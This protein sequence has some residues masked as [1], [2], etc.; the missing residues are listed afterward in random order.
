MEGMITGSINIDDAGTPGTVSKSDFLPEDR[1]SWAAVIIPSRVTKELNIALE[2]F[3]GGI[4][5]D[6]GV[7]EFH[8]ADIYG[9]R[10]QWKGIPVAKRIEIFELMAM[11]IERF[12]LPIIYQT[13]SK[14]FLNDHPE[15][16]Q[17]RSKRGAWWDLQNISHLSLLFLCFQISKYFQ[18][19]QTKFPSDFP[20]PFPT[21]VDE[22]IAKAGSI[23]E[24][25]NWGNAIQDQ[26]LSFVKSLE[27]PGI[28][29]ADFAA[30][31]ISRTQWL[32]AKQEPGKSLSEGDIK[33]MAMSG[34]LN[35][36]NLPLV[37]IDPKNHSRENYEFGLMRDRVEKGLSP[38][39]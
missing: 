32:S 20:T 13:V 17:R 24:L 11:V 26:K 33:L 3:L 29:I 21:Y 23:I 1:K 5:E 31:C 30:F 10:G 4:K 8:C 38:K 25:P 37:S 6:F 39:P 27:N 7:D 9:G 12:S 22:G 2:I 19:L 14:S 35:V 15:W 36:L 18:K 28:Q 16:S 34:R